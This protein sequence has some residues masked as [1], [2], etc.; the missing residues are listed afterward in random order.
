[1][2]L[3]AEVGKRLTQKTQS[4]HMGYGGKPA[5]TN[6][7]VC[8]ALVEAQR[9]TSAE[10]YHVFML[11][12]QPDMAALT[13]IDTDVMLR[14]MIAEE[15]RKRYEP[16]RAV[17]C[18]IEVATLMGTDQESLDRLEK[19][20]ADVIKRLWPGGRSERYT[21]L[22]AAVIDEWSRPPLCK[23]C[24]G[25]RT[26]TIEARRYDC[27]ACHSTGVDPVTTTKRAK[28]LEIDLAPYKKNWASVYEWLMQQ[29]ADMS[30]KVE[31]AGADAL[32]SDE[33]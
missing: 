26:V 16:A 18:D 25:R 17:E 3:A 24:N 23:E 2:S 32:Y 29:L 1:M 27:K 9:A 5:R 10:A 31:R 6:E 20:R 12:A 8:C 19:K 15:Y 30:G 13:D 33:D 11:R 4:F 28:A 22:I 21:K 7:D 14:R